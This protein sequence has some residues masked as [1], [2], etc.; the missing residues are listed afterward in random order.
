M[1]AASAQSRNRYGTQK[2]SHELAIVEKLLSEKDDRDKALALAEFVAKFTV[3]NADLIYGQALQAKM[4]DKPTAEQICYES[5]YI[6]IEQTLFLAKNLGCLEEFEK[7]LGKS[8]G[9][10][11][12]R[13]K[14]EFQSVTYL[15]KD[16][17]NDGSGVVTAFDNEY[18]QKMETKVCLGVKQYTNLF[19]IKNCPEEIS[20]LLVKY[21]E[22]IRE[23]MA[24]IKANLGTS[25]S[26]AALNRINDTLAQFIVSKANEIHEK[27][28]DE[29]LYKIYRALA[30]TALPYVLPVLSE[31]GPLWA[32]ANSL[33]NG[34]IPAF[35]K[36]F[37][38]KFRLHGT[39]IANQGNPIKKEKQD[40]ANQTEAE[41]R[42]ADRREQIEEQHRQDAAEKHIAVQT[43]IIIEALCGV[44]RGYLDVFQKRDSSNWPI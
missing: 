25:Q 12:D 10:S 38:T 20:S 21:A 44:T 34:G 3:S 42:A 17:P 2:C 35:R 9:S 22:E 30:I 31:I 11:F 36:V 4:T 5:F 40:A 13:F 26:T 19:T 39:S 1:D 16:R 29:G 33:K 37:E 15:A 43:D 23:S 7:Q 41:K 6:A 14:K 8:Y 24:N 18:A 28:P 32:F 27:F